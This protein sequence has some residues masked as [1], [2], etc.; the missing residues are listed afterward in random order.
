MNIKPLS[1]NSLIIY[2]SNEISKDISQ[3]VIKTYNAIL[4]KNFDFIVD[5]IPS[6]SSIVINFDMFKIDFYSFK[7][8]IENLELEDDINLED[9][10]LNIDVYY[11]VEVGLDLDSISNNTKLDIEEIVYLHSSKI[12]DIFAIG[13]L[14][15]FAYMGNV[16]EK[17]K[18][19]RLQTPRKNIPK[20]SVAIA[21]TQTA[22]YPQ[23][24][25]GGW[26]IIGQ[27]LFNC[28]NKNLD[29]L[30]PFN[31][32]SKVKFN[33]ITKKEFLSKGGII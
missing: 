5:I 18:L 15:G 27:T 26:N 29:N 8:I 22:V 9:S 24:S 4:K 13:F 2:F 31:V 19:P 3:K 20:G 25:P 28:F 14:P 23:N 12:Y 17:I 1:P 16:D 21:D 11:G 6:Y 32:G 10:L 33:P 30:S 7:N